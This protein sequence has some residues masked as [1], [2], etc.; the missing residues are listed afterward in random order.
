M[1]AVAQAAVKWELP[2]WLGFLS[3]S[4]DVS[5]GLECSGICSG[6]ERQAW[7]KHRAGVIV[8]GGWVHE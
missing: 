2:F 5:V 6:E 7:V 1:F 4:V 3:M 8:S